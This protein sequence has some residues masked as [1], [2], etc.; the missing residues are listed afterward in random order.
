MNSKDRKKFRNEKKI[1]F[2]QKKIAKKEHRVK[3]TCKFV[4]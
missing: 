4:A 1:Y 2:P 3:K